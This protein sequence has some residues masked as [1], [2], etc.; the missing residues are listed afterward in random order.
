VFNGRV[1]GWLEGRERLEDALY[2]VGFF[3]L[4]VVLYLVVPDV[5]VRWNDAVEPSPWA[6]LGLLAAAALGH[7]QRRVRPVLGLAIGCIALLGMLQLGSVPLAM[8]L[9]LGDLLYCSV[10]YTSRRLSWAVAGATG[11]VAGAAV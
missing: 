1:E 9:I 2:V 6:L 4:G 5:A 10:L 11:A 8:M 3:T 7:T